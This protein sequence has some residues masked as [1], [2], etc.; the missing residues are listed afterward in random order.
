METNWILKSVVSFGA[1]GV[2]GLVMGL[3]MNAMESGRQFDVPGVKQPSTKMLLR[4]DARRILGQARGFALFGFFFSAFETNICQMRGRDDQWNDFWGCGLTSI[5]LAIGTVQSI[6][7]Y[8]STFA[9]GGL[10]GGAMY[11]VN[12]FG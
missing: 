8:L 6:K 10:F 12:L 4:K 3:F 1:G 9:I 5:I 2:M 7:G 11:H